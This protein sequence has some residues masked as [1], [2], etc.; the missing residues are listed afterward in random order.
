MCINQ[1]LKVSDQLRSVSKPAMFYL[2]PGRRNPSSKRHTDHCA[3][4]RGAEN[5]PEHIAATRMLSK[6]MRQVDLRRFQPEENL[7]KP[8]LRKC[9]EH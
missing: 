5:R 1:C 9:V 4:P 7:K 8:A 3:T 2:C 6:A